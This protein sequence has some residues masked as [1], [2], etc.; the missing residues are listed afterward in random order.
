ME[1]KLERNYIYRIR[2]ING[3]LLLMTTNVCYEINETVEDIFNIL[4]EEK[5]KQ[6]LF[7]ELNKIY[8]NLN[9]GEIEEFIEVLL[10][11][12]VIKNVE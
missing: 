2:K 6:E 8:K 9:I 1:K 11:K 10:E 3:K 5:T 4:E 12:G 7:I